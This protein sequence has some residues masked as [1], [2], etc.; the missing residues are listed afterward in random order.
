MASAHNAEPARLRTNLSADREQRAP[1]G[2]RDWFD[3]C[4]STHYQRQVRTRDFRMGGARS[5]QVE[6]HAEGATSRKG[7]LRPKM[8]IQAYDGSYQTSAGS[9]GPVM[10]LSGLT[11][12]WSGGGMGMLP[13]PPCSFFFLEWPTKILTRLKLSQLW[14]ILCPF[15]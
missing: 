11:L 5:P 13:Q 1:Q 8:G 3:G 10:A 15:L 4:S 6:S 14:G 12:A 7:P 9:V 2:W